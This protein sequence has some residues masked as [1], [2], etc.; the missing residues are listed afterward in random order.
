MNNSKSAYL[1]KVALIGRVNVGKSALFNQLCAAQAIVSPISGATRDRVYARCELGE[2]RWCE[3][4]DCGGYQGMAT[5]DFWQ[6]SKQAV[7]EAKLTLLLLDGGTG[8]CAMDDELGLWLKTQDV[9]TLYVITKQDRPAE[10][11]LRSAEFYNAMCY[12]RDPL[13][14]SST[15][16]RGIRE[17]KLAL[18]QRLV[19][20][21]KKT[22]AHYRPPV[23]ELFTV[24]LVGKPN[25]GKSSLMNTLVSQERSCV[26]A[27]AGTTRDPVDVHVRFFNNSYQIFDTAGV[28]R[29]TKVSGQ[30]ESQSVSMSLKLINQTQLTMLV[31]D[32]TC[33]FTDQDAKIVRLA[34]KSFKP[35]VVVINKWDLVKNQDPQQQKHFLA[36]LRAAHL[37]SLSYVPI[38]FVSA[39]T[40]YGVTG[41]YTEMSK[42]VR[43][44]LMR[45]TTA[46]A[47]RVLQQIV[48]RKTPHLAKSFHRRIRFYYI[49]QVTTAPPTFVIKCNVATALKPSYKSYLEN[50]LRQEL[51]F[52][53]VPIRIFYRP[54]TAEEIAAYQPSRR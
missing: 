37:A 31:V 28:R 17:L 33:G 22:E 51:G 27:E 5:A 43:Q 46:Q 30:L 15:T 32:A 44:A 42:M 9:P 45:V 41:L 8:F 39:V 35:L 38:R 25:S 23:Q 29:R 10:I 2:H 53:C 24:T 1:G 50:R 7:A 11:H 14:I 40:K 34:Q 19:G 48:A 26:S 47:N 16:G 13:S 21:A 36:D 49:T 18:A 4:V 20:L 12:L 52:D 6:Q 54:K 3:I